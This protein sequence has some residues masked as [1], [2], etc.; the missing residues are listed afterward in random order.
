MIRLSVPALLCLVLGGC[1]GLAGKPPLAVVAPAADGVAV[2]PAGS[3]LPQQLLVALPQAGELLDS[4]RV[5]TRTERG[6]LALLAGVAWPEPLPVLLQGALVEA[7]QRV[8]FRAVGLSGSGLRGDLVLSL[9]LHRMELDYAT[10]EALVEFEALLVAQGGRA[11]G[12]RR[13]RAVASLDQR[14]ALPAS[15][16]LL[17]LSQRLLGDC[18]AWVVVASRQSAGTSG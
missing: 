14:E 2:E 12:S 15:Q 17:G 5:L 18:V 7:L 9:T 6:E 8:P 16:A 10:G 11:L 1:I 13:F 3:A 4:R